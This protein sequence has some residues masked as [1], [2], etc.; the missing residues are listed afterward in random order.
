MGLKELSLF[1]GAG[2]GV[3]GGKSLGWETVGYVEYEPFCQEIIKQRIVDGILDAAPIFGDIRTFVS[4][5][6]AEAYQGM[7]DVVSGGFPCQPFSSAG[8]QKGVGD[9]RN[10]WPATMDVIRA[11]KPEWCLLEN[12]SALLGIENGDSGQ[13]DLEDGPND[14]IRYFGTILRDL[15][16]GGYD[17]RWRVLSAADVGA[18]HRRDRVWILAKSQNTR[19][20]RR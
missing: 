14:D 8:K 7:V 9:A 1:T 13:W 17:A 15:A 2:G 3:L 12:V 10:M 18:P 6:Y 16:E 20:T 11:V 5:G 4:E 19:V